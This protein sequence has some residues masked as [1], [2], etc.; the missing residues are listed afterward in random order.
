MFQCII[1][2]LRTFRERG[3]AGMS[4]ALLSL[5]GPYSGDVAIYPT[6]AGAP[7]IKLIPVAAHLVRAS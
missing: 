4:P 1:E 7:G 5:N 3:C 6:S 2:F